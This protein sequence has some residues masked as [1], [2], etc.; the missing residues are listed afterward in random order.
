MTKPKVLVVGG[1]P[2]GIFTIGAL[3]EHCN[4]KVRDVLRIIKFLFA[5]FLTIYTKILVEIMNT[6]SR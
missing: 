6:F 3:R 4:I 5:N 1:G 2:A